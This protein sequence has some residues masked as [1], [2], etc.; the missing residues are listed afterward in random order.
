MQYLSLDYLYTHAFE[1]AIAESTHD[2]A[3]TLEN[4]ETETISLVKTYLSQY[5]DIDLIFSSTAPIE[6]GVLKKIITKTI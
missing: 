6:N 5:Y 1:R 2:F 4:L 3:E